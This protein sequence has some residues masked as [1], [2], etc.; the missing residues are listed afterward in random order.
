MPLLSEVFQMLL[1]PLHSELN[2][3]EP[4]YHDTNKYQE[5]QHNN[6]QWFQWHLTLLPNVNCLINVVNTNVVLIQCV[7]L[8]HCEIDCFQVRLWAF[9]CRPKQHIVHPQQ[10]PVMRLTD[11]RRL[12]HN[13]P[14]GN[15]MILIRSYNHILIEN[16]LIQHIILEIIGRPIQI[17]DLEH[18]VPWQYDNIHLL[19][20]I[21]FPYI[22]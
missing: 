18:W 21:N 5:H 6:R 20:D 12:F 13:V 15:D 4:N 3:N 2:Q 7:I 19:L 16:N 10:R 11:N 1:S 17:H 22:D 9:C 14:Q 8:R